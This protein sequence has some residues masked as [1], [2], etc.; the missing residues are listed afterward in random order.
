MQRQVLWL[1][2][3]C[4]VQREVDFIAP[5]EQWQTTAVLYLLN[6]RRDRVD[7][8]AVWQIARQSHDDG[9]IGVVAL[10]GQSQRA[11]NIND[12]GVNR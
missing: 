7:I 8:H 10:A 3:Q 5:I 6:K 2:A 12:N 1:E 4:T 9:D 11:I